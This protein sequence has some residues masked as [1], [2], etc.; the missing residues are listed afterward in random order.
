MEGDH[1]HESLSEVEQDAGRDKHGERAVQGV[2]EAVCRASRRLPC[3][4][5]KSAKAGW[6]CSGRFAEFFAGSGGLSRAMRKRGF[7]VEPW[8]IKF[9]A[10]FDLLQ[11]EVER[12]ALSRIRDGEYSGLWFGNPCTS[13]SRACKGNLASAGWSPPQPRPLPLHGGVD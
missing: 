7:H 12:R 13:P 3:R 11:K 6:N 4:A 9:G 1:E 5:E 8:D 10:H 2:R